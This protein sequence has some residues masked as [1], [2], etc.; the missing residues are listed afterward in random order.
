LFDPT[1]Q[2]IEYLVSTIMAELEEGAAA[3]AAADDDDDEEEEEEEGQ[4]EEEAEAGGAD[5]ISSPEDVFGV[6][7]A[8]TRNAVVE[9]NLLGR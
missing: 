9:K 7:Q 8:S 6:L 4:E 3:A 2:A 5:G 1:T